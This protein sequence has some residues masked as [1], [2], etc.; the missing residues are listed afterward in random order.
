MA[1][2]EKINTSPMKKQ[3]RPAIILATLVFLCLSFAAS[4]SVFAQQSSSSSYQINEAFFGT[5]GELEACSGSYCSKQAAGELTV[6]NTKGTA[7]QAQAGFNT[8]RT[9]WLECAIVGSPNVDLD[10]LDTGSTKT[11]SVQFQV[12]SY[13]SSGYVVQIT[14]TPPVNTGHALAAMSGGAVTPGTE[15]FGMNLAVNTAPSVGAAPVQHTESGYPTFG[16][17]VVDAKYNQANVFHFLSGDTIASSSASSG[18]TTYT[19]S[20]MANI[21]AITPAGTYTGFNSIVATATF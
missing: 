10:V 8:D 2:C 20:Y 9:E 18:Y 3:I 11:G 5:G 6:G 19:M 17:G 1:K 14:G 4:H 13:L 15:Q 21:S 16:Y 12:K 7:Y